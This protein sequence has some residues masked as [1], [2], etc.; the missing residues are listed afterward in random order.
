MNLATWPVR[1]GAAIVDAVPVVMV[2][3]IGALLGI[4]AFFYLSF[5]VGVGW[6]VYNRYLLGGRGQ[7]WG[8][9]LLGLHLI[10]EETGRPVGAGAAFVR[11]VVHVVDVICC[12]GVLFPLW[13]AK[14]QTLSDKI[15]GTLVTV[16]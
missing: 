16:E 12:I 10:K 7:S 13:D 4:D 8:K 2:L 5:A 14:R 1:V 9:K 11:D 15:L 6:T 3:G